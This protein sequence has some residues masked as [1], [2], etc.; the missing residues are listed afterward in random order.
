MTR[1][2]P[3]VL[4][5]D[6]EAAVIDI[7]QNH[8]PELTPYGINRISTD[9]VGY[10]ADQIWVLVEMEGGSY[11]YFHQKRCRIDI[12]VYVPI[13]PDSRSTALAISN[14]IQA[15]LFATQSSYIG[16]GINLQAVQVE[17]DIFRGNDKDEDPVR[18]IQSL[19]LEIL[20]TQIP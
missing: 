8:T 13:Q 4:F 6:P 14:V 9:L 1:Q 5:G 18:Y 2:F 16:H 12:T 15:S 3:F 7:L 17:T 19:R 20:G 11:K 10:S